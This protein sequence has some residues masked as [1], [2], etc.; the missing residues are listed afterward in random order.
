MEGVSR[1][2]GARGLAIVLVLS[3]VLLLLPEPAR[4]YTL[5][6]PIFIQ[7]DSELTPAFGVTGG[8]GTPADP[9]LIEGWEI[10]AASAIGI[11]IRNTSAHL[12]IR[13][14]YVHSGG[15][16]YTGVSLTNLTNAAVQNAT[17]AS[18][19]Y[20]LFL[21]DVTNLTVSSSNVTLNRY[22]GL[23]GVRVSNVTVDQTV[24]Q[25]N[26]G[27]GLSFSLAENVTVANNTARGNQ[28]EGMSLGNMW[29]V[30]VTANVIVDNNGTGVRVHESDNVTLTGNN[31]SGHR[32]GVYLE[33]ATNVTLMG[34]N[35]TG[36]GIFLGL[37]PDLNHS[38]THTITPD[39]LVDG[40]PI[41]FYRNCTGVN[42]DGVP[43]GQVI[44]ANCSNVRLANLQL[45]NADVAVQVALSRNVRL[46]S[47]NITANDEVGLHV[48]D[49]NGTVLD[50]NSVGP[51]RNGIVVRNSANTTVVGNTMTG[52]QQYGLLVLEGDNT[53]VYSNRFENNTVQAYDYST[54]PSAFNLG[55]PI[56][57]N[58]WSDYVGAD[59][60]GDGFGDT[61]YLI[62]VA[63]LD[64]YPL[65]PSGFI[66]PPSVTASVAPSV[67]APTTTIGISATV[68]ARCTSPSGVWASVL[69]P[70]GA[71]VANGTMT[72][73]GM[74]VYQYLNEYPS[75]GGY[76]VT[77]WARD[78][79]GRWG[80]DTAN[81]SIVADGQPPWVGANLVNGQ[82][83]VIVV[84]G[85]TLQID[86]WVDDRPSGM[87]D[88]SAAWY[89]WDGGPPTPMYPVQVPFDSPLEAVWAT[90]YMSGLTLGPH[91]VCEFGQDAEGNVGTVAA[92][93]TV[94]LYDGAGPLAYNVF[95]NGLTSVTIHPGDPLV[96]T[97]VVDDGGRGYSD[98]A[99]AAYTDAG[100][101]PVA[102]ATVDAGFDS[103]LE[104]VT[105]YVD[106]STWAFGLHPLCVF[107]TDVEGNLGPPECA[108]LTLVDLRPPRVEELRLNGAS[109]VSVLLGE[110]VTVTAT[111]NDTAAGGSNIASAMQRL[112]GGPYSALLPMDGAFDS[113][114]ERVS[115]TL[116]TGPLGIG[117][118]LVC[119]LGTDSWGLAS[120]STPCLA[121]FVLQPPTPPLVRVALLNGQ[122]PLSIR[123]GLPVTLSGVADDSTSG[124]DGVASANYTLGVQ[125]W[126]GTPMSP[127]DGAF[128]SSVEVVEA[129]LDTLALGV[130][131]FTLC[132]YAVDGA[133]Y[134]DT[135]G[136]CVQLVILANVP[137]SAVVTVSPS[138]A[139]FLGTVFIFA[140]AASADPDGVIVSRVWDFGDGS[141]GSGVSA[142]H[143][144]F[145]RGTFAVRLTVVDDS[146]DPGEATL[147]VQVLNRGPAASAGPDQGGRVRNS[148]V[149]LDG[150]ASTD[151]DNDALT[152]SWVQTY[153]PTVALSSASVPK[154]TFLPAFPGSY[155]F[156]LTV[157]DSQGGVASDR[158]VVTVVNVLPVAVAGPDQ[159]A[160]VG[161]L[162][163]LDGGGSGDYDGDAL[164]FAWAQLSGA[165]VALTGAATARAS[166]TASVPG[167]LT[168]VLIVADP[169]GA[170]FADAINVVVYS[171]PPVAS[172]VLDPVDVAVSEVVVANASASFDPDGSPLNYSLDWGDGTISGWQGGPVAFHAYAEPGTYSVT[173]EVRDSSGDQSP[174]VTH[175]VA[176]R[177][178]LPVAAFT[179]TPGTV[180]R[181]S[182][183]LFDAS[184]SSD[185]DGRV[186]TWEWEFGDGAS[187]LG[188]F[189]LHAFASPGAYLV[190]LRVTDDDGGQ[191]TS[192]AAVTVGNLGPQ[193]VLRTP[194]GPQVSVPSG[195][196]QT[197]A[198]T[199]TDPEGDTLHYSWE[200]DGVST[201]GDRP[202]L[203]LTAVAGS[204]VV[205]VTVSDGIA[206]DSWIWNVEGVQSPGERPSGGDPTLSL[207][208]IVLAV[209]LVL[210]GLFILLHFW[211]RHRDG[212]GK[213]PL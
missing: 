26:R 144:Y 53:T 165:P 76:N 199:A 41:L 36:D 63:S 86:A 189:A 206:E 88:V 77:V 51:A 47:N 126:P 209:A 127:S 205:R 89:T 183:A 4:A 141:G 188:T 173:L 21:Q 24:L 162:V 158:V 29:N 34:N 108:P 106:T 159:T 137:P 184:T 72:P 185:I 167:L 94:T 84:P 171:R 57:G 101:P 31:I 87:S 5:H 105:A 67:G 208:A 133:G 178:N 181:N 81:F 68:V 135:T 93:N 210:T 130:G 69:G 177:N 176:V 91:I 164:S 37:S 64:L 12:V 120:E 121:L 83:D 196:R 107:G 58:S 182:I 128:D 99:A 124:G 25:D 207:V 28:D 98:I 142:S 11:R 132:V 169:Y 39:N 203:E 38:V 116:D 149:G 110:V 131:T 156:E 145:S 97:A 3:S 100:G 153:G 6:P 20:G 49:S 75:V 114:V 111:I 46:E 23:L 187:A 170:S 71:P 139:G 168:F 66:S 15:S 43:A 104:V 211:R 112:V 204:H 9:Y 48:H 136:A 161:T 90:K 96:L 179:V 79:G 150:S 163:T 146:G 148:L 194:E 202:F 103:P 17:I 92:C 212:E 122:T 166:F 200:V 59:C 147:S 14:V 52:S 123:I 201:G 70:G 82:A 195:S 10:N 40:K 7:G 109:S 1:R 118:Q 138:S 13:S 115:G 180:A 155:E 35:F 198:V 143:A 197:F 119:V 78:G 140:S 45:G 85:S 175:Q 16:T 172:F 193:I 27:P 190:T 80:S 117:G 22:G 60:A 95:L 102:M 65:V 61:P 113:P 134:A 8:S 30:T 129:S 152:Y 74:G 54:P 56:G 160:P 186:T 2:A 213:K 42:V 125:G 62:A 174:L 73:M 19:R 32:H 33:L 55:L 44:V 18:N 154:P 191:G 151:P 50:S 192:T 157:S